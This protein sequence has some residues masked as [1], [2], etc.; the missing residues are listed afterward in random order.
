[1]A[2]KKT[3]TRDQILD[4]AYEVVAKEGFSKF[5]ARNIAATMK[6]STQPIYLEFKNME[7]L[8]HSLLTEIFDNL[9]AKIL[10]KERTGAPL[11]DLGLN[12]IEFANQQKQLYKTLFLEE[13]EDGRS[14]PQ[15]SYDLLIDLLQEDPDYQEKK[16]DLK[17]I[18]AAYWTVVSG[19]ANLVSSEVIQTNEKQLTAV[20]KETLANLSSKGSL[21]Q[22]FAKL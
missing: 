1:M 12:Y 13:D 16:S 15:F 18:A 8:K 4:A 10:P 7:D 14:I 11:V 3:I 9:S 17:V 19:L 2:R 6:C 5:T 20:L 22:V 21:S